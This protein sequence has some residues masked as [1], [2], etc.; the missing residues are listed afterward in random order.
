MVSADAKIVMVETFMA[1][2]LVFKIRVVFASFS[3]KALVLVQKK[4]VGI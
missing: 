4:V 1:K 2:L 3:F